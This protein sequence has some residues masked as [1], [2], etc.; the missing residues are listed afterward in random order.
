[1]LQVQRRLIFFWAV[2]V[3]N[4]LWLCL[5]GL[6]GA[7]VGVRLWTNIFSQ[8]VILLLI[9]LSKWK[10]SVL[11][12][13]GPV[14]FTGHALIAVI[15]FKYFPQL[16][17]ESTDIEKAP[18]F[19]IVISFLANY[20]ITTVAFVPATLYYMPVFLFTQTVYQ[21]TL[22]GAPTINSILFTNI[23]MVALAVVTQYFI[24]EDAAGR[25]L[26]KKR[27]DQQQEQLEGILQDMPEGVIVFEHADREDE[28]PQS[29]PNESA[30]Q[31]IDA[32][33]DGGF[34]SKAS[35]RKQAVNHIIHF[36]NRII[37]SIFG[38]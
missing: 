38:L 30:R 2:Y 11:H 9:C 22:T 26:E 24:Q 13:L 21:Q 16:N 29:T 34:S 5:S 31:I 32:E 25:F 19:K 12:I 20:L 7:H 6:R 15:T 37:C 10:L 8:A 17:E 35:P 14:V 1:M 23:N 4:F 28:E 36:A 3:P 18:F 33:N 27:V